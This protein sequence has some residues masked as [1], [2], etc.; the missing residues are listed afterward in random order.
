MTGHDLIKWIQDNNAED[1]P[2]MIRRAKGAEVEVVDEEDTQ[3][4]VTL[5]GGNNGQMEYKKY[6]LI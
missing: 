5:V 2:V 1:I 6:F 4:K 3:I